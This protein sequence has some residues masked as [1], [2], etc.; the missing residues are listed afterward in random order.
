MREMSRSWS[1][2]SGGIEVGCD[3]SSDVL[4]GCLEA[5]GD[6]VCSESRCCSFVCWALGLTC[7]GVEI[8]GGSGKGWVEGIWRGSSCLPGNVGS[9]KRSYESNCRI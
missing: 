7:L 2:S 4:G 5:V 6:V 9:E 3:V 8:G 1:S